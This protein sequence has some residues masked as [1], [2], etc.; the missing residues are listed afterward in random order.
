MNRCIAYTKNKKKCRGKCAPNEFFCSEVHKPLNYDTITEC[1]P[2]CI[3]PIENT[4]SLYYFKC[5]HVVHKKCYDKWLSYSKYNSP[6][7][8]FCRQNTT[9]KPEKIE[10][11]F[12]NETCKQNRIMNS[13]YN[14]QNGIDINTVDNIINTLF[15]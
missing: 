8:M 11:F 2:F 9:T 5:K 3:E 15:P 6:V 14:S 12:K 4:K 7:C 13:L 1:C 10:S